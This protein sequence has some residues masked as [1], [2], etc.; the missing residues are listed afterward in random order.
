MSKTNHELLF[1]S[2]TTEEFLTEITSLQTEIKLLAKSQV[3][4][5]ELTKNQQEEL[6]KVLHLNTD[7]ERKYQVLLNKFIMT[8]VKLGVKT[9]LSTLGT[10]YSS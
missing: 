10:A 6:D 7:L 2:K 4:M 8:L 3:D 5:T 9:C 1:Q